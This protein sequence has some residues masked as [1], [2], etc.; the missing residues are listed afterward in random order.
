MLD[1]CGDDKMD[2]KIWTKNL[3][4]LKTDKWIRHV[5]R[6]GLF[7]RILVDIMECRWRDRPGIDRVG[8]SSETDGVEAS[9]TLSYKIMHSCESFYEKNYNTSWFGIQ[10]EIWFCKLTN[11][12]RRL[13]QFVLAKM[14]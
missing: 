1:A 12:K 11:W 8:I 7:T 13:Q 5:I 9:P 3:M 10:H 4:E 6:H 2:G 14:L